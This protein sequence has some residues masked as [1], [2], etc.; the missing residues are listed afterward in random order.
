MPAAAVDPGP[1]VRRTGGGT[2]PIW[3]EGHRRRSAPA[4]W[5]RSPCLR[6]PPPQPGH[7]AGRRGRGPARSLLECGLNADAGRGGGGRR[8][9]SR[10]GP[11]ARGD[12]RRH[13]T[14]PAAWLT[15]TARRRATDA[16]G[17]ERTFRSKLPLLV[18]PVPAAADLPDRLRAV[19]GVIHLLF[20]TGHTAPSAHCSCV[21]NGSAIAEAHALIVGALSGGR[22]GPVRAP[23]GHRGPVCRGTGLRPARLDPDPAPA[24]V[25]PHQPPY[26]PEGG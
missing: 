7:P 17:P 18:E 24:R 2:S 15:T 8:A 10:V 9:S 13:P 25:Q 3:K 6:A 22:P 4:W 16:H 12:A 14:E 21:R 20:T 11:G 23:G 26:L 1:A 19:L 5:P